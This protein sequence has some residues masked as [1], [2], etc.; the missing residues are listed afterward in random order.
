MNDVQRWVARLAVAVT[1]IATPATAAVV[2]DYSPDAI[3]AFDPRAALNESTGINW[4]TRFTLA[5]NTTLTGMDIFSDSAYGAVGDGVLIRIYSGASSP[6]T[7]IGLFEDLIDAVD[8]QATTSNM[9]INRKFSLFDSAVDL[10]AG[11]YWI[12]MSGLTTDIRQ[13]INVTETPVSGFTYLL[14]GA[15]RIGGFG[16]NRQ[17][18]LRVHGDTVATPEPAMIALLGLGVAGLASRRRKRG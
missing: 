15:T 1:L 18:Y 13:E 4:A 12:G 5:S 8:T 2:V 14:D 16:E 11:T 7:L 9:T 17:A 3:G 10:D 6:S